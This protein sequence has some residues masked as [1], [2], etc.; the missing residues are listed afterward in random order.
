MDGNGFDNLVRQ[1]GRGQ[2]RRTVLRGFLGGGVVLAAAGTRSA[3]GAGPNK[4]SICHRTGNGSF[5][6]I[7]VAPAAVDAHLAHGDDF[8]GSDAHCSACGDACGDGASCN[9]SA[10][11]PDEPMGC[12]AGSEPDGNGGCVPCATGSASADGTACV[13]CAVD[14]YTDSPE[15]A[16]CSP[17]ADGY[18]TNGNTG[19]TSCT[20]V[21]G[22]GDPLICTADDQCQ[23]KCTG[24]HYDF[25]WCGTT[26]DT[27]ENVCYRADQGCTGPDYCFTAADCNPGYVCVNKDGGC[28][29]CDPYILA[30]TGQHKG[31]CNPVCVTG[32]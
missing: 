27:G 18:S 21:S 5:H 20:Q 14:T 2:S 31:V 26:F 29:G 9:G 25:C 19:A 6:L 7:S 13:P 32:D 4:V 3:L 28:G 16:V 23:S 15:Q 30:T 12:A 22:G 24:A 1:L 17:C 8:L 11:V 10:C